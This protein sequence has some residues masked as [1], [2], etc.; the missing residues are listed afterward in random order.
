MPI[1]A[2]IVD[3]S[4]LMRRLI[5]DIL[6]S[7][8]SIEIIDIAHDGKD[9]VE[10]AL[11]L[12][13]DVIT[14]DV[15]MPIM[16]GIEAVKQI[17]SSNPIPI[18]MVSALTSKDANV[19][20]DALNAGAVDFICKP[21]GSISTDIGVIGAEIVNKVKSAA[22]ARLSKNKH[23]ETSSPKAK[24]RILLVDDSPMFRKIERDIINHEP[25]ME[26]VSE[27]N[28]GKEAIDQVEKTS[29]DVILMDMDMPEMNG[30][31]AI[32]EVLKR[33]SIPIIVFS[34]RGAT[35]MDEIKLALELGA[36][37]F[38][39]KPA[40]QVSMH[41]IA[42]LIVKKIRDSYQQKEHMNSKQ[43]GIVLT[44]NILCIG[45]STGGP[46]TLAQ[47]LP[48]IPSDIPAGVLIV[49]HMPPVF[50][51]SLADRLNSIAQI[52]VK[53]AKDGDEILPGC[54]LL[55][56]GDFHM[57][58]DEKKIGGI[59]KRYISLTKEE[60]LHGVRPSVDITFSSAATIFGF[61]TIGILLTGMG[62]D[63]AN[64]MGLI[65]AK[66]GYTIAQDKQTSI[67]FG[68]PD[69]AIKLG[70]VDEILPLERIAS[71]ALYALHKIN[72]KGGAQ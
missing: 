18:V 10:K 48:Q 40:Q 30:V 35:N 61:R 5:R 4:A 34:G 27:A 50:T 71:R 58:I 1:R 21:S 12:H 7:D 56:P 11:R 39:P 60:R 52:P 47:L 66:G 6:S 64:A 49:Q 68:M 70:V 53:E 23:V 22:H 57:K 25:D 15:E 32:F 31:S 44:E 51:K 24:I 14:M 26:V 45:A 67:I 59:T 63:G 38:L 9:A 43:K 8:S 33:E 19:T 72:R 62:Q 55:A 46:Q 42:P 2:L 20:L 69:A 16:N 54:A 28:N 41:T 36:V 37:D 29:P 17:M 13:P 65:K 3:D